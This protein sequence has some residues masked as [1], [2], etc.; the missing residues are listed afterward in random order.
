MNTKRKKDRWRKMWGKQA[1]EESEKAKRRERA[2]V[3][4]KELEGTRLQ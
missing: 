2:R 4:R 1:E 3:G